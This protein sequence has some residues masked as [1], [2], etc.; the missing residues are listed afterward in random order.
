MGPRLVD[1]GQERLLPC[2]PINLKIHLF[3]KPTC[4]NLRFIWQK[5]SIGTSKAL[6]GLIYFSSIWF[7]LWLDKV[8]SQPSTFRV[9]DRKPLGP[10]CRFPYPW[11]IA[12]SRASLRCMSQ[13]GALSQPM[14]ALVRVSVSERGL[15]PYRQSWS[16]LASQGE[17]VIALFQI[18]RGTNGPK[19]VPQYL[20]W[21]RSKGR[22]PRCLTGIFTPPT[23]QQSHSL[24]DSP[25]S[26]A[27][28]MC[29]YGL[30]VWNSNLVSLRSAA[31]W[32]TP[33]PPPKAK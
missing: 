2:P 29:R 18:A 6:N 22:I 20:G 21:D 27:T 23:M 26:A 19:E 33:P 12:E 28:A 3:L 1:R 5:P 31:S 25:A 14:Q 30:V 32:Q 11:D 24:L 13:A 15:D 8:L 4:A 7:M 17:R 16:S 10:H 9:S